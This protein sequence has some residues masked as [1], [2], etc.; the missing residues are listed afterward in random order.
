[1]SCWLWSEM[2][3]F[4]CFL[5]TFVFSV[6]LLSEMWTFFCMISRC[7]WNVRP[8][9]KRNVDVLSH[10]F[11]GHICDLKSNV[12]WNM[13]VYWSD[14]LYISHAQPSVKQNVDV[15]SHDFWTHLWW[16]W[17][18]S[19]TSKCFSCDFLP[20]PLWWPIGC[21]RNSLMRFFHMFFCLEN[22]IIDAFL[23]G[24]DALFSPSALVLFWI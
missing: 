7:I 14:F 24:A 18:F 15:L 9:V 3:T 23:L 6:Q 13:D 19:D 4:F 11:F 20:K 5:V 21:L 8:A 16:G 2:L 17:W 12:K 10:D 1:M 22:F